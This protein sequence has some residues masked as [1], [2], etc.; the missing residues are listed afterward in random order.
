M[1]DEDGV[2]AGTLLAMGMLI[3]GL[4]RRQHA[5]RA[6]FATRFAAFEQPENQDQF[7]QLF[8][9]PEPAAQGDTP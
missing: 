8:F 3:E 2:P 4:E 6:E 9:R 7:R 1:V 5:A